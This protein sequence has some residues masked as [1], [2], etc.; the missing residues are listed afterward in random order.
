MVAFRPAGPVSRISTAWQCCSTP[1]VRCRGVANP[2]H[3]WI[4][5]IKSIS[6]ESALVI[7]IYLFIY[8]LIP[9]VFG[10]SISVIT[11]YFAWRR[12]PIREADKLSCALGI[13]LGVLL[14][15]AL[16]LPLVLHGFYNHSDGSFLGVYF[17]WEARQSLRLLRFCFTDQAGDQKSPRQLKASRT[18]LNVVFEPLEVVAFPSF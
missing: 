14:W 15:I 11:V 1:L 13:A 9:V 6:L 5:C 4:E 3:L 12:G 10:F 16:F 2:L 8:S 18:G 17:L 7:Y